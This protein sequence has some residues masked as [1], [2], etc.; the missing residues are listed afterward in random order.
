MKQNPAVEIPDRQ[1]LGN[2]LF[3]CGRPVMRA[4]PGHYLRQLGIAMIQRNVDELRIHGL[5][6]DGSFRKS[7]QKY[8]NYID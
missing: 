8:A 3:K 5:A 7:V 2:S 1:H 6:R 4:G